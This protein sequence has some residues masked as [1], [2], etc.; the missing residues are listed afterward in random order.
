MTDPRPEPAVARGAAEAADPGW[1]LTRIPDQRLAFLLVGGVNT[2]VGFLAFVGFDRLYA[3]L[4]PGWAP[5]LHNTVTLGCAHVLS[6][7][8]AFVL[9]RTLVFRV[10]GHVWADLVRFESVYLVS[11]GINW[12][13]LNLLTVVFRLPAVLA[14]AIVVGIIAMISFFGHKHFSFRRPGGPG[15]ADEVSS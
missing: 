12:V 2:A 14:Q 5:V 13:L 7:V 11:L 10:T 3:A 9:Y 8:I 1:L 4:A 15:G 6:V